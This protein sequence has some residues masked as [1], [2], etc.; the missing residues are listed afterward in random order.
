MRKSRR[1]FRLE[2][3]LHPNHFSD[4]N[5]HPQANQDKPII[6]LRKQP[7]SARLY[8]TAHMCAENVQAWIKDAPTRRS[9]LLSAPSPRGNTQNSTPLATAP[10]ALTQ[11][12]NS[13]PRA[14]TSVPPNN[15]P[16]SSPQS[17]TDRC[18]C[19][20]LCHCPS[21]AAEVAPAFAFAI[22]WPSPSFCI[23]QPCLC[24][25]P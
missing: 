5:G 9:Y 25:L 19:A 17:A 22:E 11:N 1:R 14:C 21:R 7:F 4:D 6:L 20:N 10:A 13:K 15:R 2:P 3:G 8:R 23:P 16:T 12:K 18:R 24:A